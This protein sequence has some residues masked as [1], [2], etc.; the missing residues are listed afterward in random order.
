MNNKVQISSI[1]LLS[2]LFY[3]IT[4]YKLINKIIPSFYLLNIF[5]I[6][7]MYLTKCDLSLKLKIFL[8]IIKILALLL[9]TK[10]CI[11]NLNYYIIGSLLLLLYYISSN[12]NKVYSCNVKNYELFIT[13]IISSI[14][15]YII[16]KYKAIN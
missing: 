7:V 12:I 6:F 4:K 13:Y 10:F 9:M 2:E 3:L 11:L 5:I 16:Y 8:T 15:Y 14:I 1:V